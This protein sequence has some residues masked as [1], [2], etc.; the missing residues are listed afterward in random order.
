MV[1]WIKTTR[2]RGKRVKKKYKSERKIEGGVKE[3][4]SE[5]EGRRR[6]NENKSKEEEEGKRKSKRK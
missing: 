1:Q 4:N 6:V 2:L 3:N 5:K